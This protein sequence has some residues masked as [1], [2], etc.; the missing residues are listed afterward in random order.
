MFNYE[1]LKELLR[2]RSV[3]QKE[4]AEAVGRHETTISRIMAG[5]LE[6]S[7]KL[8]GRIADYFGVKVDDLLTK[9]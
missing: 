7:L 4:L 2:S 9:N 5:D 6:P 1:K 8:A 3:E